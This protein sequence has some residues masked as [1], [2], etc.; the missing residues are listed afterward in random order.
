MSPSAV[1]FVGDPVRLPDHNVVRRGTVWS[2]RIL[3]AVPA[4]FRYH[5][6][7]RAS[8]VPLASPVSES[9]SLPFVYSLLLENFSSVVFDITRILTRL[10]TPERF[11]CVEIMYLL[12]K[13][14]NGTIRAYDGKPL[15][16]FCYTPG[17]SVCRQLWTPLLFV[18]VWNAEERDRG[19]L[20][21]LKHV[22]VA[23]QSACGPIAFR[24]AANHRW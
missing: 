18:Q 7:V 5:N 1:R 14:Q 8:S 13:C 19:L 23:V 24:A 10:R 4:L 9:P 11:C 21:L 22:R 15:A 20:A 6:A 2:P 12:W 17:A 3:L 16:E